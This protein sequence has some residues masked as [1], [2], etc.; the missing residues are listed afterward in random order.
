[1][2]QDVF[3]LAGVQPPTQ[4]AQ[5]AQ[6]QDV[7]QLA[8]IAPPAAQGMQS[9]SPSGIFNA[10]SE[11]SKIPL[12]A[13]SGLAES[14]HDLL[15]MPHDLASSGALSYAASPLGAL[16]G[17]FLAPQQMSQLNQ[18]LASNIP[19]Q[20]NYNFSQM[21]GVQNPGLADNLTQGAF[22]YA[23]AAIGGLDGA[24]N[25]GKAAASLIRP[26]PV[27]DSII[28]NLGQGQ[29][30]EGNAQAL[31]NG[32]KTAYQNSVAQGKALYDPVTQ[33]YGNTPIYA[34][35]DVPNGAYQALDSNILGSDR[36]LN[37]LNQQFTQSPTFNNAHILQSQL[38]SAVRKLQAN[39]A[40]GT[41]SVADRGTMQDYQDA[42]DALQTDMGSFL[43]SQNPAAANQYQ[44]AS[45]N[46]A[47]NVAPFTEN[48]RISQLAKG[49][50]TNPNLTKLHNVFAN[51]EPEMQKVISQMPSNTPNQILFNKLGQTANGKPN[52]LLNAYQNLDKQGIGS[53]VTPDLQQQFEKLGSTISN[54]NRVINTG[55]GGAAASG[56]Y[57][58][59]H[60]ISHHLGWS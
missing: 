17:H 59:W 9:N 11:L 55:L 41:L 15:N 30:L 12:S 2:G 24:I 5:S 51:P 3:Q 43:N 37:S 58:L 53:Y 18:K 4:A 27:M 60:L 28:Q 10:T 1:M 56:A 40:K 22:H 35:T 26:Q 23:P 32:L 25:V 20:P 7:F 8:N 13:L 57:G 49:D 45:A 48:P 34:N 50:I 52:N 36:R 38:G 47:Q 21:L 6:P 31:A 29:S 16:V 44:G 46:W 54:K 33:A 39:D 19:S 14:G 42:R